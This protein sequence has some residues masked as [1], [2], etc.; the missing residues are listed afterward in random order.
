M[1]LPKLKMISNAHL[2]DDQSNKSII[3]LEI[4]VCLNPDESTFQMDRE[5]LKSKVSLPTHH[6]LTISLDF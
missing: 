1:S 2:E 4:E 5:I 6:L 3:K